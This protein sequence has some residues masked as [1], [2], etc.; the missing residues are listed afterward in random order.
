VARARYLWLVSVVISGASGLLGN[1]LLASCPEG[2]EIHAL[3][4]PGSNF[5]ASRDVRLHEV[6][7]TDPS[8]VESAL[9]SLNPDAIVNSAAEGRVDAVQGKKNEFRPLNVEMPRVLSRYA[10]EHGVKMVHISSNAVFS[11]RSSTYSDTDALDPINDY[12]ILKQEAEAAVLG[13][14]S[15]ALIVRPILMYGWPQGSGRTNPAA[16][17]I[18][19]LCSVQQ[20]KLVYEVCSQLLYEGKSAQAVLQ[21][22]QESVLGTVNVGGGARPSLHEFAQLVA[23]VFDLN[24]SFIDSVSMS[25]FPALARLPAETNLDLCRLR[26]KLEFKVYSPADRLQVL[27]ESEPKLN[28][29]S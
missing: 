19:A 1:Y 20:I 22:V 13:E 24:E 4:R 18:F 17:W 9:L 15:E 8:E 10:H 12:G 5:V 25:V 28:A 14:N 7:L 3:V 29:A 27:K 23:Q 16:S 2:T 26:A 6:N 21:G 11:G